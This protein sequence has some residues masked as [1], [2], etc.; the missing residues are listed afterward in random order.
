M[1]PLPVVLITTVPVAGAVQLHHRVAPQVL[2]P[3]P[4]G[5]PASVVAP[6]V[7]PV[8]VA[9]GPLRMIRLA[10]LSLASGS[11]TAVTALVAVKLWRPRLSVATA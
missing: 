7:E 8:T 11:S 10:K 2:K 1:K 5:S 3:L 9:C 6:T 4:V